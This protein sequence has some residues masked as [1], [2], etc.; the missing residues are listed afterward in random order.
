[1]TNGVLI[2]EVAQIPIGE[3]RVFS[4]AGRRVAVFHTH[5][6]GVFATQADCPH[7]RG[8]LADGLIGGTTVVCPLHDR[9]FDLRT[10]VGLSGAGIDL[11]VYP[12]SLDDD[13]KIWLVVPASA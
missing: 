11:Q 8:P 1:M 9:A 12:A 5:A 10:G 6:G 2:G 4:V 13:G 3:G 7:Q